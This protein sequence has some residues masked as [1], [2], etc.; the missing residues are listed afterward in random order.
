M[1]SIRNPWDNSPVGDVAVHGPDDVDRMIA[2]AN[3]AFAET[4]RWPSHR[5][6]DILSQVAATLESESESFARC[7]VAETGKTIRDARV[8]T[9]RAA[10]VF[11]IAA[12]ESRRIGGEVLPLDITPGN[13]N[14]FGW[15]RRL[16]RGPVAAIT[17]FN[18]PLNLVAHKVAPALAAGC[19]VVLKPSER[20]PLTALALQDAVRRA[21]WPIDAFAVATPEFPDAVARKLAETPDCPVFTF[22]GSDRI[23]WEL[24]RLSFRKQTILELGGNAGVLVCRD[25]DLDRAASRCVTGA[26]A[27]AGQVC[28]SVQRIAVHRDCF[29]AFVERYIAL[30]DRL[31]LGDPSDPE[32]DIGPMIDAAAADRVEQTVTDA[33]ARGAAALLPLRRQPHNLLAPCLLT[34]TRPDWEIC[35]SEVFGPVAVV[36]RFESDHEAMDWIADSRYGLQAGIFTRDIGRV[37]DAADRWDVGCLLHDEVPTWRLDT[38]PYGGE[39]D[40]GTGREGVRWAIES[41]TRPQLIALRRPDSGL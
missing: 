23:G 35:A 2:S 16:P 29:D 39:R 9:S 5:R 21:G 19:P 25:A 30:A 7:I 27:N 20:A 40:S 10:F 8:E 24:A 41:M 17:P 31:R 37:L 12:E 28:I 11:R 32:T 6:H 38:M 36:E 3:S 26:H 34:N 15:I 22:T 4:R 13:D 1:R 33:L 18:F 14:R